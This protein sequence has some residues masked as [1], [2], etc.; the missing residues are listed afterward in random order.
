MRTFTTPL[1][2]AA[3]LAP[4]LGAQ[5]QSK[6]SGDRKTRVAAIKK[7]FDD[8]QNAFFERYQKAKDDAERQAIA[9]DSPKAGAWVQRLWP[10]VD[11]AAGDEVAADALAW[12]LGFAEARTD[13]DKALGLLSQHHVASPSIGDVCSS[14]MYEP[15]RKGVDFLEMVTASNKSDDVR[16]KAMFSLAK[17]LA[18]ALDSAARLAGDASEPEL[19]KRMEEYFGADGIAWLRGLDH[20]KTA[21]RVERLFESVGAE[22]GTVRMYGRTLAEVAKGELFEI[23]N[24][25]IGKTAPDIVGKDADGVEFKLGDYRGKVVVLDFWGEW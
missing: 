18:N 22:F 8:A 13:K 17:M 5:E 19:Q 11:E 24:L 6:D 21:A 12:I 1:L 9:K 16:G 23:R 20:A 2:V 3:L 10:I 15:S 14:L 25:A 4:M 7:E